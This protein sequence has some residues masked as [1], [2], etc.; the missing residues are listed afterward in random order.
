MIFAF[1]LQ[2]QYVWGQCIYKSDTNQMD[3]SQLAPLFY[4]QCADQRGP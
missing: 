3:V 4:S 2:M 1:D